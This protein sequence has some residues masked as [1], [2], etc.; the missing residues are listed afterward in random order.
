MDRL[1]GARLGIVCVALAAASLAIGCAPPMS[2]RPIGGLPL[3]RNAEVGAAFVRVGA[4]P[5]VEESWQGV[6]QAWGSLRV[7]PALDLSAVTAFDNSG[8]AFGAAAK[9]AYVRGSRVWLGVEGEAG[10]A[11]A[12]LALPA[13]LRIV[14]ELRVYTAPRIGNWGSEWTPGI[15]VGVSVPIYGG[16]VLRAEGQVS[17]ADFKYY[18]RRFLAA[19]AVVFQ[20]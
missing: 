16:F 19:G 9:L 15:P 2:L 1:V 18:N 3:D 4:R 7:S 8:F 6:G 10:W 20:W 17:W 14:G 12:A 5:Y 13:S 11:W